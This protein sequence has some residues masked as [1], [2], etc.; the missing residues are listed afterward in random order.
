MSVSKRTKR[1]YIRLTPSELE[2]VREQAELS[3]LSLSE[4]VRRRVSGR[5]VKS[6]IEVK[7]LSE[8][9]RQGGLLKYVFEES[10][11]MYSSKTAVALDNLNSFIKEL[12][13]TVLNGNEKSEN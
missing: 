7:M 5:K 2:N 11:G 9:R 3:G 4:Y 13:S 8:L 1:I 10:R 6:R 12:E